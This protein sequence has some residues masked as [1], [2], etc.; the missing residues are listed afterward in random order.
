MARFG[1]QPSV[2]VVV[3]V[4]G[5][6]AAVLRLVDLET[7]PAGFARSEAATALAARSIGTGRFP[8]LL[9]QETAPAFLWLMWPFGELLDWTVTA[10][11]VPAALLGTLVAIGSA[12]WVRRVMGPIWG[13]IGGLLAATW[14]PLLLHSRVGLPEV[15]AGAATTLGFWF[16]SESRHDARN[17]SVWAIAAGVA[18]GAGAWF[19][20]AALLLLP[21]AMAVIVVARMAGHEHAASDR[22]AAPPR[23]TALAL[24]GLLIV[25]APLVVQATVEPDTLRTRIERDWDGD[26]Q[27]ERGGGPADIARDIGAT[28]GSIGVDG[29][30]AP[31]ANL[32][33]RP[34]LDP[35]LAL[36]SLVGVVALLRTSTHALHAAS[37][38]WL[39]AGLLV[40][41]LIAPGH[42]GLLLA[43][44][45]VLLLLPLLGMRTAV[46]L[47]TQRWSTLRPAVIVVVA[48]SV[49]A[50]AGWSL[51]DYWENWTGSERVYQAFDGDLRATLD[52]V[53]ELPRDAGPI[54]LAT[55]NHDEQVR[56]L[57][58]GHAYNVIDG[59][60]TLTIPATGVG[61]LVIPAS[62][63]LDPELRAIVERGTRL[64]ERRAP[65]GTTA[66]E[67]WRLGPETRDALPTTVPTIRFPGEINL[68][69]FDIRPD[70]GNAA[71]TGRLPDPPGVIV[72]LVWSVPRGTPERLA[73]IRLIPADPIYSGD[74]RTSSVPIDPG[75]RIPGAGERELIVTRAS[76]VVP[77]TPDQIVDIQAGLLT[78]DLALLPPTSPPS[79]IAGNYAL[80]NRVQYIEP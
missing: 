20:V 27:R 4:V 59:R 54:S 13:L 65:D 19:S 60:T 68:V 30:D 26:G 34:L 45:P 43:A 25:A 3:A 15:G 14:F 12:L 5:I 78:P 33:G 40:S 36:W 75:E 72:T 77:E 63:P 23:T 66:A 42:P 41:A 1:R 46:E 62:T 18:F 9:D 48:V 29:Y 51:W 56:Y 24:V 67:I 71:T 16:L 38:I 74:V 44:T 79:A 31:F 2:A 50:S 11:R 76:I 61:Y 53:G 39:V 10:A 35:L 22:P 7:T 57:A 55:W 28:L 17:G 32:P 70:L 52:A 64:D 47:V 69:G 21:V 73:Q 49:V 37:L 8:S 80:L 58:P 6:V